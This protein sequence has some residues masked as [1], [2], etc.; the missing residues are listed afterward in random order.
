MHGISASWCETR[1]TFAWTPTS[2][3]RKY[4]RRRFSLRFLNIPPQR[5][6]AIS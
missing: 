2:S 6:G 4:N 5:N 3:R 1:V